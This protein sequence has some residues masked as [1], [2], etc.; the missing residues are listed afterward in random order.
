[1]HTVVPLLLAHV[2]APAARPYTSPFL[3][4]SYYN[5]RTGQY[6][7]GPR[8]LCS[9]A[10]GVVLC[11][12]IRAALMQ[13]LLVPLGRSWGVAK[14]KNI[15]RFAEQ[16]WMLA[17]YSVAWPF[18]MVCTMAALGF[19]FSLSARTD[20]I[21]ILGVANHVSLTSTSTTTRLITST[22]NS[23]GPDGPRGSLTGS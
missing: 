14:R 8:D 3:S 6:G 22:F 2:V 23:C 11:I 21:S 1:M 15:T 17:Y 12:G 16:G 13:Q 9:V 19:D 18:G 10:F 4:L 5:P 20:T 7:V